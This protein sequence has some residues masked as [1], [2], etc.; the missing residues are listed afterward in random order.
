MDIAYSSNVLEHVPDPERMA[1]EMLRVTR[2]GGLVVLSYTL[3][4][5][6]W[7]G[8][9]TSPWHYLGGE[10]AA[11]RYE[12]RHGKRP[13]NRYGESLFPL[14]GGRMMRWAR[15]QRGRSSSPAFPV[16]PVVGML[17]QPRTGAARAGDVEPVAGPPANMTATLVAPV[18]AT[19]EDVRTARVTAYADWLHPC[20]LSRSLSCSSRAISCRTPSSTFSWTRRGSSLTAGSCGTRQVRPVSFAT[21]PTD[22][23]SRWDLSSS[24]AISS[25]SRRGWFSAA[26]GRW[27]WWSRS[28]ALACWRPGSASEPRPLD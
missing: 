14:S 25:R 26:G 27:S 23:C 18:R 3:W 12:R 4:L 21:R 5:S 24:S 15:D 17:G 28:T 20:S 1:E 10:R 2:P 19:R 6:P 11:R 8:H 16:P 9:E 22:T 13:K 7:G